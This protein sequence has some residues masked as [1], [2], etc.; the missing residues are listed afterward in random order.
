VILEPR[1][2]LGGQRGGLGIHPERG[3]KI[4]PAGE[5]IFHRGKPGFDHAGG[6]HPVARAHPAEVK[7]LF[8]M[9]AVTVPVGNA[10]CLLHRIGQDVAHT[11][12]I[13]FVQGS[14]D[15]GGAKG[16]AET[17]R[18]VPGR[19]LELGIERHGRA[20]A[21]VVAQRHGANEIAPAKVALLGNRQ[22]GGNDGAT[23]MKPAAEMGIV[24]LVGMPRH[25][26]GQ[27][28]I[29]RR[30]KK[31]N[32]DD[33]RLLRTPCPLDE[34]GGEPAGAETRTGQDRGQSVQDMLFRLRHAAAD[35]GRARPRY[36]PIIARPRLTIHLATRSKAPR[37]DLL[38]SKCHCI[39]SKARNL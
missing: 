30:K 31:R 28:R 38:R 35:P 14:G 4:V 2:E 23:G 29:R 10:G 37:C 9:L 12:R 26:V 11:L 20:R 39:Y 3:E 33:G 32:A 8:D 25:A 21:D 5:W 15:S 22:G 18:A 17:M 19:R 16:R 27:G 7:G 6:A 36:I 13:E 24:G 1:P 34:A